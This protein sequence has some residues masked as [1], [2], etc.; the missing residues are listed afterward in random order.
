[1]IEIAGWM[2]G[3]FVAAFFLGRWF[4]SFRRSRRRQRKGRL[5]QA[6]SEREQPDRKS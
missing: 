3:A 4:E 2:V 5:R 6:Q 1:M